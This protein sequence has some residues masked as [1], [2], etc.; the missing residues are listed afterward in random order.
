MK[1]TN[2]AE[3]DAL[4]KPFAERLDS[5]GKQ[6]QDA[7]GEERKQQGELSGGS[8]NSSTSIQKMSEEAHNLTQ[9]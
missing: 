4:S 8:S 9:A 3:N 1:K 2:K 7:Y 5:F 6:V